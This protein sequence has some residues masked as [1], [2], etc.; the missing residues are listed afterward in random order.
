MAFVYILYSK[1]LNKFYIG[2]CL[3]LDLRTNDHLKKKQ[4]GFTSNADDWE[5]FLSISGLEYKPARKIETHIKKM[6]SRK[7]VE[8][9]KRYP[10]LREKLIKKYT[11]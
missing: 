5:L 6:K 7:Y 11:I 4:D 1:K 10:D 8:D 3:D 2:S 9:L